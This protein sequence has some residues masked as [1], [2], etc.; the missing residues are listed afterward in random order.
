FPRSC[1][2]PTT[3]KCTPTVKCGR[4]LVIN[5]ARFVPWALR[6]VRLEQKA[7]P[8]LIITNGLLVQYKVS[9][10]WWSAFID[11]QFPIDLEIPMPCLNPVA[12]ILFASSLR[13]H[14][15]GEAAAPFL[16]F[17]EEALVNIANPFAFT[18]VGAGN[19]NFRLNDDS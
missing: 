18:E 7:V 16:P 15:D 5:R 1:T 11:F 3:L 17:V 4:V 6:G 8:L 13:M 12:D 9:V 10:G 2:I 14:V 19:Y